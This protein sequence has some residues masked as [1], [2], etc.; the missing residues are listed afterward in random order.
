M[1]VRVGASSRRIPV[2][3]A[4]WVERPRSSGSTLRSA[5]H[6]SGLRSCSFG[7]YSASCSAT[8]CSGSTVRIRIGSIAAYASRVPRVSAKW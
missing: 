1:S 2:T 3:H 4:R 6:W 7:P 5:Q 8:V